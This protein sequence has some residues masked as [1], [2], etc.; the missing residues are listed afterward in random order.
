MTRPPPGLTLAL[1]LAVLISVGAGL[2]WWFWPARW[3]P[4]EPTETTVRVGGDRRPAWAR[5]ARPPT[6][7]PQTAP[8]SSQVPLDE[9][10]WPPT[11]PVQA[12]PPEPGPAWVNGM[13]VDLDDRRV[14]DGSVVARCTG[15][16]P[17]TGE[18]L[19]TFRR[20]TR[21]DEGWFELEIRAPAECVLRGRRKDGLLL[22]RSTPHDLYI[23]P[24][25][26]LEIDL[27]VPSER[28]GGIG[29]NIRRVDE[30]VE[31]RRV[32]EGT[33]AWEAGLRRGDVVVAVDGEPVGD[34]DIHAFIEEMTG[35]EGSEVAFTV[36]VEDNEG[37][38]EQ[39]H[40]VERQFLDRDL[41][42]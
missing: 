27:L 10:D 9:L 13:L 14:E 36:R 26:A 40:Q 32:H 41:L 12:P 17:A 29:V 31:I 5:R 24:D 30:G 28:T 18:T 25:E 34:K 15:I 1:A 11:A 23:E 16:D 6:L 7:A 4:P 42:R 39:T 33:P 2:A 35:P 21:V 20:A 38:F 37:P 19:G 3:T 22:A 8:P